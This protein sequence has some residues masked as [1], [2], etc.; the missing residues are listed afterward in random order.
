[1]PDL[2]AIG[3]GLN[4]VKAATE[5]VKTMIG[6]RDSAKLI[7]NTVKLNS[8]IL[9]VQK[10]LAD[11]HAEQTTLLQTVRE[12]E[13]EIARMKTWETE[14][15]RYEL[16]DLGA[17]AFACT[18][19][20]NAQGAGPFHAICANCYERG[21]KS[22]LQDTRDLTRMP[23]MIWGCPNCGSKIVIGQWPP[24]FVQEGP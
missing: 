19:K 16:K 12:L 2:I 7:E 14:K 8:E 22:Y 1:M 9:S 21:E 15:Q 5:I 23:Y 11:A 20:Q 17:G 24:A 6:L 13:Q 4:A 10:A 3:Q 18:I